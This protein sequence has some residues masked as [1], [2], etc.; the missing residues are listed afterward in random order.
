MTTPCKVDY[1]SVHLTYLNENI[2]VSSSVNIS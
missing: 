2:T 1:V